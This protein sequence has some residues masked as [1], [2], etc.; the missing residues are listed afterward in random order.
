MVNQYQDEKAQQVFSLIDTGRIMKM[1]FEGLSLLDYAINAALVISS[2]AMHK[3]DKA[4]LITFS[5][6]VCDTVP[7]SRQRGHIQAI[8]QILYAQATDY[9]ETDMESLYVTV[10]RKVHQRSLLL[11]FTNFESMHGLERQLP[12][13]RRLAKQ[14]LVV[15]IFFLNTELERDIQD[16]PM[17]T[18]A[19]YIRTIAERTIHEKRLISKELER[20]GM[21]AIL[22][23]PQDLTV[24][25]INRYLEMKARG[26]W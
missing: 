26:T 21:P 7:A 12:Y 3:E 15:P 11:L 14:H 1:P 6:K 22:C 4:G 19:I 20:H 18:E 23:R 17:N 2:I 16:R 25:V 24:S 5:N 13:L 8:L 9:K 10:K